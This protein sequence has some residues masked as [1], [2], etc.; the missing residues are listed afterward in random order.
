MATSRRYIY[1][2]PQ[3]SARNYCAVKSASSSSFRP[4]FPDVA[5]V[6]CNITSD[7]RALRADTAT[8]WFAPVSIA[9]VAANSFRDGP[10]HYA[11]FQSLHIFNTRTVLTAGKH[12]SGAS[13]LHLLSGRTVDTAYYQAAGFTSDKAPPGTSGGVV[14]NAEC[15]VLGVT[16]ASAEHGVFAGLE[17]VDQ[18][19]S[20]PSPSASASPLNPPLVARLPSLASLCLLAPRC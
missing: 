13:S 7:M 18:Y 5:T 14:L 6:T 3:I 15:G 19:F 10:Y 1:R 17:A 2:V 9:G 16:V 11:D 20:S 8:G 12:A 4:Y